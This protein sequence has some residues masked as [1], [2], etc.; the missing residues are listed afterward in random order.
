MKFD[1]QRFNTLGTYDPKKVL[2]IFGGYEIKGFAE[3]SIIS[4]KPLGEGIGSIV[5][6]DGS[7][8]R[9][10]SNDNRHEVTLYLNMASSS[11]DVLSVIHARDKSVG[12]GVLP[13][14]IKDLS[15]RTTFVDTQAWIV[16]EPE[17]GRSKE[18]DDVEWTLHTA[19]GI[20]YVGGHD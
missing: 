20:L 2:V 17:I 10:I 5:G 15:G 11:N 6:C 16:N 12:D 19:G 4:V 18:P 3:D 13:L 1:L 9:T 14:V 7:V 8:V